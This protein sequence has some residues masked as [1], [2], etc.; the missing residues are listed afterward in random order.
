MVQ[1]AAPTVDAWLAEVDPA[2][3]PVLEQVRASAL[4]NLPG[5]T[6]TM[7]YGMP[8]YARDAKTDPAFAFNSQKQYISLYV[9]PRVHA[10]HAEAMKG[11]D[12]GKSCIRFRK[13]EKID[14]ALLDAMLA[15]TA[16]LD[17]RS[18]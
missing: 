8:T 11:L 7:R 3:R 4:R 2:R 13:P 9:S 5:L 12:A 17:E 18:C 10:L 1:S 14:M 6:E 16:R 15:D